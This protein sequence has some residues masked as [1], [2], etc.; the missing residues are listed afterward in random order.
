MD[1]RYWEAISM[2]ILGMVKMMR[3]DITQVSVASPFPGATSCV[4]IA[5]GQVRG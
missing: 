3:S 1:K 4:L 2:N 5:L